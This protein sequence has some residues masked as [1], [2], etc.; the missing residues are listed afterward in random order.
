MLRHILGTEASFFRSMCQTR[1]Y[2]GCG[3]L[4]ATGTRLIAGRDFT[5][6][7][8]YDDRH[9]AQV[10]E[11]LAREFWG[12]PQS[13]IGQRIRQSSKDPWREIVGVVEDVRDDGLDQAASSNV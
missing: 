6:P 1:S 13:A 10:S 11:N 3:A 4:Q 8:L 9:V 7:D 12:S 2:T 5:W